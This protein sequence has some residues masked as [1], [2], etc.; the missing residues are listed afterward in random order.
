M[1]VQLIFICFN[2]SQ[3]TNAQVNQSINPKQLPVVLLNQDT[4]D[5]KVI[6]HTYSDSIG[7]EFKS[8]CLLEQSKPDFVFVENC[9][10]CIL[11]TYKQEQLI[12]E[13]LAYDGYGI[14]YFKEYY[15]NGALKVAGTFEDNIA[16]QWSLLMA[17]GKLEVKTGDWT[18]YDSTGR[19]THSK[20]FTSGIQSPINE[21]LK[22]KD[23]YQILINKQTIDFNNVIKFDE[24]PLIT[25]MAN[26]SLL[27]SDEENKISILFEIIA[28]GHPHIQLL[29][30][31]NTFRK[32][33]IISIL[34]AADINESDYVMDEYAFDLFPG[35]INTRY[36]IEIL[37]EN[38]I[39]YFEELLLHP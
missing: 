3:I 27:T 6:Y 7:T 4:I 32:L 17:T 14:G 33:D 22:T 23:K 26:D 13:M 21:E 8:I 31:L 16:N 39:I 12:K 28:P 2:L 38:E 18:Y 36:F 19:L 15:Q 20:F 35:D 11:K 25:L 29:F 34:K 24:L 1:R 10:P 5:S 9:R 37:N 30:S